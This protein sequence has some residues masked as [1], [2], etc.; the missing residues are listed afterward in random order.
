MSSRP[1]VSPILLALLAAGF[2]MTAHAQHGDRAPAPR[3]EEGLEVGRPHSLI[4]RGITSFGADIADGWAYVLGGYF[5]QPHD[6]WRKYQSRDFY[7][8]NLLDGGVEA[9]PF[10]GETLQSVALTTTPDGSL[11]RMGGMSIQE[12]RDLLSIDAVERYR[13]DAREWTELPKLT[14]P[15]SSHEACIIGDTLYVVGG[16]RL[17]ADGRPEWYDHALALDLSESAPEWRE[18]EQPFQRRALAVAPLGNSVVAIGGITSEGD[19]SS[20]V[21]VYHP[22]RDEWTQGPDLPSMAFG[23]AACSVGDRVFASA[24]DGVLYSW[25]HGDEAWHE[26]GAFAFPRFF[27]Q[28]VPSPFDAGELVAIGGTGRSGRSRHVE[29]IRLDGATPSD[30]AELVATWTV[31]SPGA[32]RN[33]QA[34]LLHGEGLHLFG[35]NRSVGQ[36]DFEAE[37]FLSEGHRLDLGTLRFAPLGDYPAHRQT[38]ASVASRGGRKAY[39]IGGFGHDGEVARSF[40][41]VFAYDFEEDAWTEG[42]AKLPEPRSQIGLARN[43]RE[44]WVFGGLDYDSRREGRREQFRHVTEVLRWTPGKDEFV[45]TGIEMPTPRRA[46]AGAALDDRYYLI[47][48]MRDDFELVEECH[49]FDFDAEAFSPISAPSRPRLSADLVA[50]DDRLFLVGGS[51]R[52]ADG[53]DLA[54]DRS[55]EMYDPATD[56]WSVVLEEL[57]FDPTHMR[58]LPFRGHLLLYSAHDERPIARVALVRPPVR[59]RV[60]REG[61]GF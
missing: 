3:F 34:V 56:R 7:R 59:A 22:D 39:A 25:R 8:I 43:G 50:L 12:N 54:P 33:R 32:A 4:P 20:R 37:N 38:I 27:H 26:V 61:A 30:Q 14:T 29:T 58:A 13:P 16:W 18:I 19:V 2:A 60:R 51:S 31:P 53:D 9:L 45:R 42:E 15:R 11:I 28:M 10:F 44:L 55:I 48:G 24:G 40:D 36:H 57:P 52:R 5:G 46:F 35:G 47:G 49:R 23:A 6:Y 21:D 17:V 1:S 41:D